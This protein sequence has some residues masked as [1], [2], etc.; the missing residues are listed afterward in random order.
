VSASPGPQDWIL[1][2]NVDRIEFDP[3]G[4][5]KITLI[6]E[7]MVLMAVGLLAVMD[8]IRITFAEKAQLYDAL[9]PGLYDIGLGLILIVAGLAYFISQRRKAFG[10]IKES[11]KKESRD[12]KIMM[13]SM[14]VVM[15]IYIFLV[16]LI[17]YLFASAAF[18]FLINRVVGSRSWFANLATTT[19]MTVSYYVIFVIWMGMIFPRGVLFNF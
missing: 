7:V 10:G 11:T 13:A 15:I 4:Y 14:V 16:D 19:L 3:K 5:M 9:G 12:Y 2:R 8:G 18:F 6:I 1:G 17:G